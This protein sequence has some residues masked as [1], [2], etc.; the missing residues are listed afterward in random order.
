[1]LEWTDF[2]V[3]TPSWDALPQDERDEVMVFLEVNDVDANATYRVEFGVKSMIVHQYEHNADGRPFARGN[4]V[5]TLP[6]RRIRYAPDHERTIRR[7][8]RSL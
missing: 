1:M 3:G 2:H 4:R 6:P 7:Q 5:A 8:R